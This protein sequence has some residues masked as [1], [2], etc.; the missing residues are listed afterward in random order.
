MCLNLIY[1]RGYSA[2]GHFFNFV[3]LRFGFWFE[4]RRHHLLVGLFL[5]GFGHL[6]FVCIP[7]FIEPF[8]IFQLQDASLQ[9]PL[10][11]IRCFAEHKVH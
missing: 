7:L 11:H 1:F 3:L 4:D 9:G 2:S 6:C 8:P 10:E 5:F